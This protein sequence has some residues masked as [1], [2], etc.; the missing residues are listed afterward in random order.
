M[1]STKFQKRILFIP[2]INCFIIFIWI[3]NCFKSKNSGKIFLKA[4]LLAFIYLTTVIIIDIILTKGFY[5]SLTFV[6][7][8]N[9]VMLYIMPLSFGFGLISFQIKL[10]RCK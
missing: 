4:L 2:I 6:T 8:K 7:I 1:V 10:E 5:N 9:Y 3:F